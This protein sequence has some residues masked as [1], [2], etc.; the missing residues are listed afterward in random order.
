MAAGGIGETP[1]F[2]LL[3]AKMYGSA[4]VGRGGVEYFGRIRRHLS[5]ARAERKS[6]DFISYEANVPPS[7][8]LPTSYEVSIVR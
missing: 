4:R 6:A 7:P 5:V 1:R 8:L 3:S 2:R